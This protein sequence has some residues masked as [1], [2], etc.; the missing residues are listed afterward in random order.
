MRI[1]FPSLILLYIYTPYSLNLP[2]TKDH[3]KKTKGGRLRE[4]GAIPRFSIF[5]LATRTFVYVYVALRR[6]HTSSLTVVVTSV[7]CAGLTAL[8]SV[9]IVPYE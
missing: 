5:Y 4:K 8:Y 1:G 9:H 2:L 6:S 3:S 7:P